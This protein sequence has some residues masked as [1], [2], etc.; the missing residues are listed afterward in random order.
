MSAIQYL[1][2]YIIGSVLVGVTLLGVAGWREWR[3]WPAPAD[4][5]SKI[6]RV[7]PR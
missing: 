3:R 7:K 4:W 2:P 5:Q 1:A 6:G